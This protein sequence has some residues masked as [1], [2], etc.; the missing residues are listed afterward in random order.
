MSRHRLP[1][2]WYDPDTEVLFLCTDGGLVRSATGER[3]GGVDRAINVG[4]SWS[5]SDA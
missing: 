2:D 1:V 5:D 3:I 4:D